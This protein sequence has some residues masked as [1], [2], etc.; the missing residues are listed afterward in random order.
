MST[1]V[2]LNLRQSPISHAFWATKIVCAAASSIHEVMMLIKVHLPHTELTWQNVGRSQQTGISN[3]SSK[4]QGLFLL[5]IQKSVS[6]WQPQYKDKS[7]DSVKKNLTVFGRHNYML[8]AIGRGQKTNGELSE[9][10]AFIMRQMQKRMFETY[11]KNRLF[12]FSLLSLL[13]F[14]I[15]LPPYPEAANPWLMKTTWIFVIEVYCLFVGL[16]GFLTS[17]SATRLSRGQVQRLT[18]DNFTCCHTETEQ[19][20]HDFR[21]S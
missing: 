19:R 3:R 10:V 16:G 21:L 20:D 9:W 13:Y 11:K 6:T 5:R 18:S 4:I 2:L 12:N 14:N 1:V 7:A 8:S 17:S 15:R